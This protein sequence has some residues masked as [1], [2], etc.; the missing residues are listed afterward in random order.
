MENYLEQ[1]W[2]KLCNRL[3]VEEVDKKHALSTYKALEYFYSHPQRGY[4][5]LN[6]HIRHCLKELDIVIHQDIAFINPEA[7]EYAIWFHDAIYDTKIHGIEEQCANLAYNNA[8]LLYHSKGFANTVFE[9]VLAT[10]H[11][12]EPKNINEQLICDIDLS[13]L[14]IPPVEFDQNATF[15]R[16][17]Y[18]WK[19]DVDFAKG[20]MAI[21]KKY[22]DRQNIYNTKYFRDKYQAQAR[23]NLLRSMAN[24]S[25][26]LD[27]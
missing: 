12:D 18:G 7:L 14:G 2:L 3:P 15:I 21:L 16:E 10:R 22:L 9:L 26:M 20:R 23:E 4:H 19:S 6:N 25:R 13:P 5:N 11:I 27:K 8:M 17:E 24:L 1:H